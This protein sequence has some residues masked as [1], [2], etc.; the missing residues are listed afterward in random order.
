M[1]LDVKKDETV[2][3]LGGVG[4]ESGGG[5]DVNKALSEHWLF[6]K[7]M[8]EIAAELIRRHVQ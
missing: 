1:H 3:E 7:C 4:V 6:K 2:H 5:S 8:C